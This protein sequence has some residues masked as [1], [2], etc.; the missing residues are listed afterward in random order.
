MFKG[1]SKWKLFENEQCKG[2]CEVYVKYNEVRLFICFVIF[3]VQSE[4]LFCLNFDVINFVFYGNEFGEV[5]CHV[6]IISGWLECLVMFNKI[7]N[8]V[9]RLH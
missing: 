7:Y 1:K 5:K 8:Y 9:S 3:N 6:N 2:Y 4:I